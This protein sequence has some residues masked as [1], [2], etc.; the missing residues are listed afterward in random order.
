M[1]KMPVPFL[2][3]RQQYESIRKEI[4]P[5]LLRVAESQ[6]FILGPEVD[7]LEK[8]IAAYCQAKFSVGCTSGSDALM[9][10]LMALGLKA[11]DEVL[12]P[13]F[14]FFATAGAIAR[15]GIQPIFVDIEPA[16]YNMCPI[17]TEKALAQHKRVKAIIP[18]H[19]Y[20]LACDVDAF[21][22]IGKKHGI[23]IIDDCAQAIGARDASGH[24]VGSRCDIG[25]F[26]F[27]PTKNLGC[28][29]DGGILTTNSPTIDD[30]LKMAR[31]HGSKVRYYHEFVGVNA[32]LDAMQA[33][34]LRVKL[35]HLESWHAARAR[36]ASI[37]DAA[38]AAAGAHSTDVS[39]ST[40]GLA[41]R[42][43]WCPPSPARH[44]Y[45]QY[46]IRVGEGLRD[47]TRAH[48]AAQGIGSEIYYPVPLHLQTCF[49]YC[50]QGVGSLPETERATHETI[51]LPIFPELT[52]AQV[53][54][55][56]SEIIAFVESKRPAAVGAR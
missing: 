32:R 54:H 16:T 4:E 39:W 43:P 10:A 31:V 28:M 56:A 22:A 55:V 12:C 45:N 11:G 7:E 33:A 15:L 44:V 50:Q 46:V 17:A 6:R 3:L 37:Y 24:P 40:G 9:L 26:S 5:V 49:A 20:G 47:E 35:P 34:V 53:E 1:P 36:N 14:T 29:G 30:Y 41:V 42:Y 21:V 8:E 19:L 13:S 23:P 2:D 48:L 38:F 18:V 27:F 25:T 51:A 52:A